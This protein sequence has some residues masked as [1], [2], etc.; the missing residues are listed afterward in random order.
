[1]NNTF[2]RKALTLPYWPDVV[3][4]GRQTN[5]KTV[6]TFG[7]GFFDSK[8]LS[9]QHAEVWADRE[10]RVLIRDVKSSNGTFVNGQRLSAENRESPPH[11]LREGD[12]LE[13][14]IDIVG[15][16]QKT[17]LHHKVAARVDYAGIVLAKPD[18][19]ELNIDF[20][21]L[22]AA[23]NGWLT[24]A[25]PAGAH[26]GP[27]R[28]RTGSQDGGAGLSGGGST[29]GPAL[30]NAR[31]GPVGAIGPP[32]RNANFWMTPVSIE[33]IVKRLNVS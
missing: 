13:L 32:M 30:T 29:F 27:A 31:V 20:G 6:P 25:V 15:D 17:V 7:N 19:L 21:D 8:V 16:D 5:G 1:M 28:S 3:R 11:V 10:G 22:K 9:R 33:Q 14:G 4:I 12:V 2:E 26:S 23:A 24:G 18:L